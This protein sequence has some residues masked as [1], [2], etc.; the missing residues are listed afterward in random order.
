MKLIPEKIDSLSPEKYK[1]VMERSMEDIS[2]IFEDVRNIVNDIKTRGD[3]VTLEFTLTNLDAGQPAS[4]IGFSDDLGATLTGL[5][6]DGEAIRGS[7]EIA[8]VPPE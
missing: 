4:G 2:S 3:A 1:A 8:V 7:D 6:F 5:T